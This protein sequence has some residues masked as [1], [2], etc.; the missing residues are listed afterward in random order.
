ML[1]SSFNP[2]GG[3]HRGDDPVGDVIDVGERAGL[4][5]GAEDLQGTLT[6]EHLVDQVGHGVRDAGLGVGQLA[7]AVG[8]EGA[9]DRVGQAVLLDGRRGSRPRR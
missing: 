3:A 8:V 6:G 2:A 4:L 5:A 7:G 9:A 1:K